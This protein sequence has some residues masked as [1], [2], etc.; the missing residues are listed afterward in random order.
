MLAEVRRELRN[1]NVHAY[2]TFHVVYGRKPLPPEAQRLGVETPSALESLDTE[3]S[4]ERVALDRAPPQPPFSTQPDGALPRQDETAIESPQQILV[5]ALSPSHS[6]GSST[7]GVS[8]DVGSITDETTG[9][10][11]DCADISWLS[12]Q[13]RDLVDRIMRNLCAYLDSRATVGATTAAGVTEAAKAEENTQPPTENSESGVGAE[14]G[15][16]DSR[17]RHASELKRSNPNENGEDDDGDGDNRRHK[18]QHM[19]PLDKDESR[20]HGKFA[21]PY[22]KRNRRKYSKWT[23]CPGPGWD[24]VYRVKQVAVMPL[25]IFCHLLT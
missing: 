15:R 18:R 9:T 20:E 25:Q 1:R 7:R 3:P 21:C 10:E 23:T 17:I 11:S 12:R 5:P 13:R 22:Y 2:S 19:A 16:G 4:E 6:P 24:E 8:D 14:G